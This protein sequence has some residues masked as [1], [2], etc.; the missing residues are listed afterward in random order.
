MKGN[1]GFLED[2]LTRKPTLENTSGCFPTSAFAFHRLTPYFD[3]LHTLVE[4]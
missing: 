2:P 4:T 3:L 1:P